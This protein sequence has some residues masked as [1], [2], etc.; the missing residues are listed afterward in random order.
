VNS[1]TAAGSAPICVTCGMQYPPSH[2]PSSGCAICQDSRQFVN[3]AG[4][5]WTTLDLV[6]RN[7]SNTL[8][9]EEAGLFS[10]HTRP[11]FAI[12]QRAFLL[13]TSEGNVLWDCVAL[14]DDATR[15]WAQKLGGISAIAVSHPHY[16]T[17]MVEWSHA[18]GN[19]PVFVHESDRA[20]VMRPD[21][22]VKF[23]SG[24]T[25]QLPGGTTLIRCGGHFDGYQVLH[26]VS[27]QD[28]QGVLLSGDQPQICMDRSWVSFMYSYPNY[29][30]LNRL[31]V[32]NIIAALKPF[33]FDR[34]YGAF[35]GRQLREHA[36][37]IVERSA[38]RYIRA[39]SD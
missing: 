9:E 18:F 17:S 24:E 39:I 26:L 4:Q 16:Y 33:A 5:S 31:A 25:R 20:W 14:L 32:T 35:P 22:V 12:S 8:I 29:I 1:A 23:W 15:A 11:D 30:P 34:F 21:A 7:H 19:A 10:I 2:P 3:W 28:G 27:A 38:Q 13:R 37:E 36:K 6:A